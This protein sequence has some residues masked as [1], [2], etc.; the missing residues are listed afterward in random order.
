MCTTGP[1]I[2]FVVCA[3]GLHTFALHASVSSQHLM[4]NS[5]G[6]FI[7]NTNIKVKKNTFPLLK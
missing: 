4:E 6:E 5:L 2:Q 1:V 3:C 7:D